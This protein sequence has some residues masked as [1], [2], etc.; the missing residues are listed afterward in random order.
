MSVTLSMLDSGRTYCIESFEILAVDSKNRVSFGGILWNTT[1]EIDDFPL[2]IG[3]SD[4]LYLASIDL[5]FFDPSGVI[6]VFL[7]PRQQGQVLFQEPW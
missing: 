6:S 3:V 5:T 1:L 4:N 7:A 2:L